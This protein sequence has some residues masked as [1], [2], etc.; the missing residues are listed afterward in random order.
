LEYHL[1]FYLIN[2][3]YILL[4]RK[5]NNGC[6]FLGMVAMSNT[7]DDLQRDRWER[8][9]SLEEFD[10]QIAQGKNVT[11]EKHRFILY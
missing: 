5:K 8:A 4:S 6:G 10:C 7:F 9:R 1:Y 2:L 11:V 3:I